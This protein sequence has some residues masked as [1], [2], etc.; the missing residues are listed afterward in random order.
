[1]VCGLGED[2]VEREGPGVGVDILTSSIHNL[3]NNSRLWK[4]MLLLLFLKNQRL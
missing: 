1:M 3:D 2:K 4:I